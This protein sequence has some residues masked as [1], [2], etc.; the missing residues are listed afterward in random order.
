MS[1]CRPGRALDGTLQMR[2]QL[3]TGRG[4][5]A[6]QHADEVEAGRRPA[7]RQVGPKS[8]A[9]AVANDGTPHLAGN[10]EPHARLT[11]L[12]VHHRHHEEGTRPGA[13]SNTSEPLEI[14]PQPKSPDQADR[15]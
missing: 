5:G 10:S 6:G 8:T 9:K 7:R 4:L 1:R 15:R 13:A 3:G 2:A 14:P 11:D 12:V